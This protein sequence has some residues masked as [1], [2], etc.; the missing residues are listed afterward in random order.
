MANP[1]IEKRLIK[2]GTKLCIRRIE[3][4]GTMITPSDIKALK[5]KTFSPILQSVY[6]IL[7][8]I[9]F[10]FGMWVQFSIGNMP[11]SMGLLLIGFLN[12]AYGIQG[13]PKPASGIEGLDFT[14]LTAEITRSFTEQQDKS[15][16]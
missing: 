3:Q 9:L 2:E 5:V 4:E 11:V 16:E 12:I 6:A 15:R 13:A 1:F 8:T 7:G 10:V 14:N